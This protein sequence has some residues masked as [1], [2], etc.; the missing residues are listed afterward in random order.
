MARQINIEL[1]DDI[2]GTALGEEGVTIYFGLNGTD[3]SI[4]LSKENADEF[5][6]VLDPYVRNAQ[7][8]SANS[9]RGGGKSRAEKGT[10]SK[11]VRDWAR[12]NGY[13]VSDR[14]RIPADILRAFAAAH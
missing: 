11:A 14:G 6:G 1:I 3:Y 9:R 5:Y 13:D 2:D 10:D 7:K 8:V 12:E 4:D